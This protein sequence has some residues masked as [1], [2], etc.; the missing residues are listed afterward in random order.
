MTLL[1][2][3]NGMD[4]IATF[5]LWQDFK[6]RLGSNSEVATV[7][8]YNLELALYAPSLFAMTR[9]FLVDKDAV[10]ALR[11][12]FEAENKALEALLDTITRSLGLGVINMASYVH[13]QWL[14]ECLSVKVPSKYDPKIGKSRPT[15]DRDALEKIS[16]QHPDLTPIC[17]IIIA[18]Q[19]RAKM[20]TVLQPEL[21]DKDGRMRTGY[22]ISGTVTDRWSSGK[23]C[24]WTGMNMQNVKRDEDENKVGHASIRSAFIADPGKKLLNIDLK[25][26]DTWAIALEIFLYTGDD[27]LLKMLQAGDVHTQVAKMIWPNLGWTG[28]KRADRKIAEQF[29]YLQY[30]YRF[31]CKKGG[32]GTNYYGSA[33]A[34]AMQMKIPRHFAENFQHKY[35]R[36]VPGL[37]PWQHETIK[38]LQTTGRLVNLFG[39]ERCFHGRLDDNKVH[40][41]AIGWKGQSVTAGVINRALLAMFNLQQ[42]RPKLGLEFLAQVHDSYTGQFEQTAE[43]EMLSLCEPAMAVPITVISRATG[44]ILTIS[45]PIEISTGWNWA[46][47]TNYNPDGL[48]EYTGTVD[49]RT[50]QKTPKLQ[51]PRFL[52][53]RVSGVY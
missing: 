9:G 37:R 42:T 49:V 18:Y 36:A 44:E 2:R 15:T 27:S 14:F 23:N 34:L 24:L 29:F 41:E 7:E 22:K 12:Q 4:T 25:G 43:A 51:K 6:T 16:K 47:A 53:R 45:I 33:A 8:Q 48:R 39:R 50:R 20:L 21:T 26:A 3:Y 17:N 52:D 31:M 30:D 32:H 35:F 1:Q 10:T 13:K 38:E 19:N 40:K 28:D 5:D 11:T 46:K